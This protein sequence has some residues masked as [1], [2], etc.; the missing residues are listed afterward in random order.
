[1]VASLNNISE[2]HASAMCLRSNSPISVSVVRIFIRCSGVML[3]I[4]TISAIR[5]VSMK[6]ANFACEQCGLVIVE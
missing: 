1:M 3:F 6:A 4:V 5:I 2:V